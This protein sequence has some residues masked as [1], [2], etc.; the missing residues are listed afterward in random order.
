MRAAD[1]GKLAQAAI[2]A[3]PRMALVD[4]TRARPFPDPQDL[5]RFNLLEAARIV[6]GDAEHLLVII[7]SLHSWASAWRVSSATEYDTLN[8][9][10][11]ALQRLAAE[12]KCPVLFVSERNRSSMDSGGLNAGAGTRPIEYSAETI[13]DLNRSADAKADGDGEVTLSLKLEKNRHGA[14][15]KKI[16]LKFHGA[17]QRFSAE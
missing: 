4:A 11:E 2:E 15:G 13:I 5:K 17:T 14:S 1:A 7:D 8:M 6:Q 10:I 9:A 16:G 12:L 3:A